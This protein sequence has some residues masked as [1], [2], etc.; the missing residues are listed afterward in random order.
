MDNLTRQEVLEKISD[1]L[2][3]N[4]LRQIATVNPEFILTAQKDDEFK[5]ILNASDLNVAD[6]F[7]LNLVFWRK[8]ERLRERLAGADLVEDILKM[9]QA[10]KLS[11][12]VACKKEG[13]SSSEEVKNILKAKFDGL[14]VGGEDIDT[15]RSL[16]YARDDKNNINQYNIVFVNFGAP[17]QEKF[18]YSLKD[19]KDSK[20]RL[21]IGVGGSFDF[22]TNK[23]KRAPVLVRRFGLEWLYRL[24]QQPKRMK[25]IWNAVIIFPIKIIF[26][27]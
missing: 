14:E 17:N 24:I 26:Q 6:G 7:G 8:G 19:K 25:R 13:L 15:N 23:L 9:A 4:V 22:L 20:M 18:I 16:D 21:A 11:V 1:F 10:Q 27:K 2:N 3:G 5:K 12:F